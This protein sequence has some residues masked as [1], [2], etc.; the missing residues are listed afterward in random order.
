[1]SWLW[2]CHD[3]CLMMII[4]GLNTLSLRSRN[5]HQCRHHQ[6]SI[7]VVATTI[8]MIIT[9]RVIVIVAISNA[10]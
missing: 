6:S 5:C 8:I 3:Q 2:H 10:I 4:S 9:M 1:M 7:N